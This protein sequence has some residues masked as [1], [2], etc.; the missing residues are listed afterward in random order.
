MAWIQFAVLLLQLANK[1][2]S[3]RQREG[4]LAEGEQRAYTKQLAENARRAK[5]A[6]ESDARIDKM[7]DAEVLEELKNDFRD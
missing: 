3:W 1:I 6:K 2:V 7:S 4:L 5:L